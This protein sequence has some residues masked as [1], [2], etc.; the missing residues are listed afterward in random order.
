MPRGYSNASIDCIEVTV[1]EAEFFRELAEDISP[2]EIEFVKR[3]LRDA[4]KHDLVVDWKTSGPLLKFNDEKRGNFF[5]L[6]G[7]DLWADFSCTDF[8]SG[9]VRNMASRMFGRTISTNL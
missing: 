7:F 6:G 9:V 5:T 2:E 8:Y 3:T 1:T 4:S